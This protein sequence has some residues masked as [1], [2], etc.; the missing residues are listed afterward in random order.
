MTTHFTVQNID[1]ATVIEFKTASLLD[2]LD[3]QNIADNLYPIIDNQDKRH[4]ILDFERVEYLSS[5]AIGIVLT[6]NK[7]LAALKHSRLILCGVGT[8]LM[9]LIKITRLDKVLTIKPTQTEA[10]NAMIL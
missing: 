6:V 1:K 2:P 10:L 4:I 7:K 8:R 9:D 3:L 5:Q